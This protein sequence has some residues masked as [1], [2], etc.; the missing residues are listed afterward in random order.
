MNQPQINQT[1]G[2]NDPLIDFSNVA[3]QIASSDDLTHACETIDR[4]LSIYGAKLGSVLLSD[5]NGQH[6]AVRAYRNMPAALVSL[7]SQFADRGGCPIVRAALRLKQPFDA[8]SI[9]Q[10]HYSDFLEQRFFKELARLGGQRT[11]VVPFIFGSGMAIFVVRF[12]RSVDYAKHHQDILDFVGQSVFAL[13]AKFP[14]LFKL[15]EPKKLTLLQAKVLFFVSVGMSRDEICKSVG[16]SELTISQLLD[17]ATKRLRAKSTAHAVAM[18]LAMGEFSNIN[19][20]ELEV[21]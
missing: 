18:A 19:F 1:E 2:P 17:H 21:I 11:F 16:L 20:G 4:T 5:L 14:E 10:K 12:N 13:I 7:S 9:D 15:F 3:Q 6:K 8:L